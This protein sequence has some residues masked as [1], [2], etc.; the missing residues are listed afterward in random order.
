MNLFTTENFTKYALSS[1]IGR[2]NIVTRNGENALS[3]KANV[4]YNSGS[5]VQILKDEFIPGVRYVFLLYVDTDDLYSSDKNVPGG[6]IVYYTDGSSKNLTVTGNKSEPIGWQ[7]VYYVT[8][9]GKDVSHVV[10][11]YW[12]SIAFYCRWDSHIIPLGTPSLTKQGVF[13]I[14]NLHSNYTFS[15]PA[16]ISASGDISS[17][18]FYEI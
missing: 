9:E 4:F 15:E 8:T 10:V 2:G 13:N 3:L 6:L 16:A 12:T 17:T 11:Y 7:E 18:T 1:S 5:H 14:E